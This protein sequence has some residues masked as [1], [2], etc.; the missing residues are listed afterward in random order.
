[1]NIWWWNI[2]DTWIKVCFAENPYLWEVL[3]WKTSWTLSISWDPQS[4]PLPPSSPIFC[5]NRVL[6]ELQI[7]RFLL[8]DDLYLGLVWPSW[9][10]GCAMLSNFLPPVF[11][12][13]QLT[14]SGFIPSIGNITTVRASFMSIESVACTLEASMCG[15]QPVNAFMISVS[16]NQSYYRQQLLSV[17]YDSNCYDCSTDGCT[18]RVRCYVWCTAGCRCCW[19]RGRRSVVITSWFDLPA[20]I[21][22]F[23]FFEGSGREWLRMKL[24]M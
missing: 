5:T 23:F 21:F 3:S 8:F 12:S 16:N 4:H 11:L 24:T 19:G 18:Q 9:L 17:S 6:L 10:S 20:K 15:S 22:F 14:D 1:M 2:A 7:K 13:K